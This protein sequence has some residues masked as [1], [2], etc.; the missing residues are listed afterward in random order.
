M[1]RQYPWMHLHWRL[2]LRN[3]KARGGGV[4]WKTLMRRTIRACA[5]TFNIHTLIV[6]CLA[7][8]SVYVCYSLD[9]RYNMDFTMVALG[10]TFPITFTISQAF[11]RRERATQ[12]ISALKASVVS[13]YWMHR[14]WGCVQGG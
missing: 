6:L 7:C 4:P 3:D 2:F 12:S 13:L 9:F 1:V 10:T 11:A 8:L 14:D 5:Y